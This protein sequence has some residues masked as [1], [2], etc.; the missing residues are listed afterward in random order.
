MDVP[1][2]SKQ[3]SVCYN[4]IPPIFGRVCCT[5]AGTKPDKKNKIITLLKEGETSS[6]II[7]NK[8]RCTV[9]YVSVV[10]NELLQEL[11]RSQE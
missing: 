1:S 6:V 5:I 4:L 2:I 3:R 9:A 8:A 7:T 11:L 10:K